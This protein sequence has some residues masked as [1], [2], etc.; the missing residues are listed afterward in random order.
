MSKPR[1]P[2]TSKTTKSREKKATSNYIQEELA[3]MRNL[4][5][6]EDDSKSMAILG[7]LRIKSGIKL[8]GEKQ[9]QLAQLIKDNKI[10]FIK[11]AAGTGKTF[12]VIKTT[13]ECMIEQPEVYRQILITKPIIEAGG[14]SLGFLPGGIDSKIDPYMHSFESTFK[15]IITPGDYKAMVDSN[16]IK[17]VPLPFMRGNTFQNCI[18][19]FDEAQNTTKLGLKLFLTRAG[20]DSKLIVLGDIDQPDITFKNGEVS[21]LEHAYE[22]L[23]DTK[24]IGFFEFGIEDIVR[25]QILKD[26]IRKY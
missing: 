25:S 9:K 23:Q 4:R 12:T 18:A 19:I 5:E 10:V 6:Q 1:A 26:I 3:D 2:R 17:T 13:L 11:G 14:E 7:R 20:E 16:L 21:G 15:K 8:K 24:D 22:R